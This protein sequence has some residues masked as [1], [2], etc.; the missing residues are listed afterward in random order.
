[1][2]RTLSCFRCSS[3]VLAIEG[4]RALG[5]D[6]EYRLCQ[7]CDMMEVEDEYHFIMICPLYEMLRKRLIPSWSYT[8]PSV[9]K[10]YSLMSCN[11]NET[12]SNLAVFIQNAFK[13]RQD[14]LD[15]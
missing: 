10:F 7:V 11:S 6:I 9:N 5:L 2:R 3:H 8:N 14:V 1:M 15:L 13:L 12:I 4:G